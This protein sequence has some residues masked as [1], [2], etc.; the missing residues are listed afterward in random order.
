MYLPLVTAWTKQYV[1]FQYST[2]TL[3][4]DSN[5]AGTGKAGTKVIVA[6]GRQLKGCSVK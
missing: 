3:E 6:F 2:G 4:A 1:Y 5:V